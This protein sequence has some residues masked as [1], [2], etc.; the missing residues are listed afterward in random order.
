M[1]PQSI[2][3]E[4]DDF[5]G[6]GTAT[7]LPIATVSCNRPQ[8]LLDTRQE[9][10]EQDGMILD[11]QTSWRTNLSSM[12]KRNSFRAHKWLK[13]KW[14]SA[15]LN[16][17]LVFHSCMWIY[18]FRD[19]LHETFSKILE[20]ENRKK[21][22]YLVKTS[23]HKLLYG[24]VSERNEKQVTEVEEQLMHA[25]TL[26]HSRWWLETTTRRYGSLLVWHRDKKLIWPEDDCLSSPSRLVRRLLSGAA[27][28][29]GHNHRQS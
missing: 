21:Y 23:S 5:A 20:H 12:V 2:C 29:G 22:K 19:A 7:C 15:C 4:N 24:T 6:T 25:S 28:V 26:K 17:Y 16:N 13:Q 9:D 14:H 1:P 10:C 27:H 3:A 8:Q 18:N 11:G